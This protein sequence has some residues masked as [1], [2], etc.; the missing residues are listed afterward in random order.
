MAP[1]PPHRSA[2]A[3]RRGSI[4]AIFVAAYLALA[5]VV[6]AGVWTAARQDARAALE[7]AERNATSSVLLLA[8][9]ADRA[10]QGVDLYMRSL[11]DSFRTSD[12]TFGQFLEEITPLIESGM[13]QLPQAQGWGIGD[14]SGLIRMAF[15]NDR[16]GLSVADTPL[17]R[18]LATDRERRYFHSRPGV[19]PFT[20][21]RIILMAWPLRDRQGVFRGAIATGLSQQYFH[22][23]MSRLAGNG[24]VHG[25]ALAYTDGTILAGSGFGAPS[26]DGSWNLPKVAT[27]GANQPQSMSDVRNHEVEETIGGVRSRWHIAIASVATFGHIAVTAVDLNAVMRPVDRRALL[28]SGF[29]IICM[30]G[31]ALVLWLILR[32]L[33]AQQRA[34]EAA[35][36]ANRAKSE[37]LAVLSH[38]IRTPMNAILGMN[39]LLRSAPDLPDRLRRHASVIRSA[40]ENLLAILNDMI[41]VSKM[42]ARLLELEV[43]D[44]DVE[45]LVAEVIGLHQPSAAEKGLYLVVERPNGPIPRLRGDPTRIQ[46]ILGNLVGNAVKFTASGGVT[47][48]V[49]VEGDDPSPVPGSAVRLRLQVADTGVGIPADRRDRLFRPFMQ[50]DSST[51]RRYGGSGLGLVICQRLADMMGGTISFES[52]E[53][54]GSAFRVE[55]PLAVAAAAARRPNDRAVA[56]RLAKLSV[57]VAEDS[58]LN[59]EL[60]REILQAAGHRVAIAEDGAEAVRAATAERF[61]VILMDVRMPGMDGVEAARTIRGLSGP[62]A[63]VPIVGLTA[64]ATDSQRQ[65]CLAAG[66]D[67]VLVKPVDFARFWQ[68]LATLVASPRETPATAPEAERSPQGE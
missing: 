50:A 66:M 2:A 21:E 48:T 1:E 25:A 44:V 52:E 3:R 36:A 27:D 10:I 13:R 37:F 45:Q 39:R 9:H 41:D 31:L 6:A 28:M 32:T 17:F 47:V 15:N 5:V 42:E 61:D 60:M 46:Q 68:T 62:Q 33:T 58:P 53:G 26:S 63:S 29:A 4:V 12:T 20:S 67:A 59:Q 38:E 23:V 19:I 49:A 51:T 40:G 55:L 7:A 30:G 24:D 57:L 65:E 35:E 43:V 16:I 64:D 54:K 22:T 18:A 56:P 11:A 8:E 34:L 14:A